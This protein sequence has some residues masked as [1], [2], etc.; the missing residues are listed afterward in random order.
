MTSEEEPTSAPALEEPATTPP[1][2]FHITPRPVPDPKL[3]QLRLALQA[4]HHPSMVEPGIERLWIIRARTALQQ[5]IKF[6]EQGRS[7]V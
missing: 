4:L 7:G 5:A 1:L 2:V 6:A 3:V